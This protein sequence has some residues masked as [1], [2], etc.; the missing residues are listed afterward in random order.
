MAL[1]QQTPAVSEAN[2]TPPTLTA[3]LLGPVFFLICFGLGY[4]TLNRYQARAG[5]DASV[6]YRVVQGIPT[7]QH[8]PNV[9]Y[10]ESRK[11]VPYVAR[12]FYL[13]AKG[14]L[15]SWDPVFFGLLVANSLFC[16]AT[17]CLIT[18]LG[19]RCI[20]D[21][22]VALLGALLYLLN[23]N[24]S[25]QQLAGLVDSGESFFLIALAAALFANR[26]YLLL[27]I[28]V[29]G[30]AAKETFVPMA[31]I[32]AGVWWLA[33][34]TQP[35]RF[36]RW[37]WIGAMGAGGLATVSF[38]QS[39]EAGFAVWPWSYA[40]TQSA[41]SSFISALVACFADH[42]FPYVFAWLL[43]LGVWRF[44]RFPIRWVAASGAAALAALLMGAWHNAGGNVAR[45]MFD[46]AGPLLALSAAVLLVP[47][48]ALTAKQLGAKQVT[49]LW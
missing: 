42:G 34:R 12:P 4:A 43:P 3:L 24:I 21:D 47:S 19:R 40:S 25:N 17:A 11:L 35:R 31:V 46:A 29:L 44:N 14:H 20:G 8:P 5:E 9:P 39:R 15:G 48:H 10:Q 30:A 41:G 37:C 13:L 28:G 49:R 18:H 23:F 45:A 27:P 16:A 1:A 32:F 2:G 7:G 22:T 33:D 26:W 6:Y 36:S 38:L